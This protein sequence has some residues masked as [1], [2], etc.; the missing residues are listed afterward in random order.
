MYYLK[1]FPCC[2]NTIEKDDTRQGQPKAT[3]SKCDN[4][5]LTSRD[6][7]T[8][9]TKIRLEMSFQWLENQVYRTE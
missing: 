2:I 8:S 4:P 1:N 9:P 5:K 7:N 3:D 6:H